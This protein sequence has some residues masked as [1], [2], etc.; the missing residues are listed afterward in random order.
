MVLESLGSSTQSTTR[1]RR[2]YLWIAGRYLKPNRRT[3]LSFKHYPPLKSF[4]AICF[5]DFPTL[6]R[7]SFAIFCSPARDNEADYTAWGH[8][9]VV[10][11]WG[12]KLEELDEKPGIAYA[13]SN[14]PTL[15]LS[16]S[17]PLL[18]LSQ[19]TISHLDL[20][21]HSSAVTRSL[22]QCF[23]NPSPS[24]LLDQAQS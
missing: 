13:D 23:L 10:D 18:L 20:H 2:S 11:P 16:P 24:L 7:Q 22:S 17:P 14:M 15:P 3:P 9:M 21:A 6:C 19:P 12:E 5:D 4:S 8:S 1:A